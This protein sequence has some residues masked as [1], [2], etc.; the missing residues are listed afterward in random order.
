MFLKR[1]D[2]HG[3]KSFKDKTS[4]DFN[5]GITTIVGPNGSGKSNIADGFRWVLGEQRVKALR[6]KKGEDVIFNGT[7]THKPLGVSSVVMHIDNS[8]RHLNTPYEEMKIGRKIYRSGESEY[9]INGAVCRLK[10]IHDLFH[11]TGLGKDSFSIIGQG[12]I[13]NVL[14]AKP[15]DRRGMIEELAGIVK[16][17]N[18]KDESLKKIASA[19]LNL[20]RVLD[21]LNELKSNYDYLKNESAKAERFLE[22]K[23]KADQL[24]LSLIVAD[25]TERDSELSVLEEELSNLKDSVAGLLNQLEEKEVTYEQNKMTLLSLEDILGEKRE[26]MLSLKDLIAS[27]NTEIIKDETLL[28]S[29]E[30]KSET[31]STEINELANKKETLATIYEDKLVE[32]KKWQ[33]LIN[34]QKIEIKEMELKLKNEVDNKDRLYN[35]EQSI[36]H[37]LIDLFQTIAVLNNEI[38]SAEEDQEQL[39]KKSLYFVE[40]KQQLEDQ[41]GAF[42]KTIE[43]TKEALAKLEKELRQMNAAIEE[44]QHRKKALEHEKALLEEDYRKENRVY[45]EVNSK[46]SALKDIDREYQGYYSGVKNILVEKEN[47]HFKSIYGA[48]GQLIEVDKNYEKSIE[49]ALGGALQNVVVATSQ[50]AKKA[51]SFLKQNHKG[52]CTF[53]PL[54]VIKERQ[55]GNNFKPL[56][57]E[58]GV[59]GLGKDLLKVDSKFQLVVNHLLGNV[60]IVDTVD[61]GIAVAKKAN[62]QIKIVTLEGEQFNP[63]GSLTGGNNGKISSLLS[64][65]RM[66][67]ELEVTVAEKKKVL[68]AI[69]TKGDSINKELYPLEG[70]IAASF[71]RRK[72]LENEV[73]A[74]NQKL[75]LMK[76]EEAGKVDKI[77]SMDFDVANTRDEIEGLDKEKDLLNKRLLE[78]SER[79]ETLGELRESKKTEG[80]SLK[81]IIE[82]TQTVILNE[83]MAL[84]TLEEKENALGEFLAAYYLEQD[85]MVSLNERKTTQLNE[86]ETAEKEAK[87][88]LD[89]NQLLK[90]DKENEYESLIVFIQERDTGKDNLRI[91]NMSLEKEIKNLNGAVKKEETVL[92]EKEIKKAKLETDKQNKLAILQEKFELLPF[93]AMEKAIPLENKEEQRKE[94]EKLAGEISR[95][96]AVNIGAIDEFQ[97]VSD[98]LLFL[99]DQEG[100]LRESIDSLQTIVNDIDQIMI[101]RFKE[102]FTELNA[103]FKETYNAL[104]NGGEAF[105]E[106]TD[107]EDILNCGIEIFSKPP[108]KTPKSLSSL[109]GGERA[110][111]ALALL[112]S[113]LKIK[114]SPLCIIDEADASLD[115]RNVINFANYL[116]TYADKTQFIVIS[117]RQGTIEGSD[118]LYGVT[119]DKTGISKMI[120]VSMDKK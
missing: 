119:M 24:E 29:L 17:R 75:A 93:E 19:E 36:H 15:E 84:A 94:Q 12:E 112:F 46:Y 34:N 95:L 72:D 3:F 99:Q 107:K 48:V 4:L 108:G 87:V 109:S 22:L 28:T 38:K 76:Q 105:M 61:T 16:Y 81:S 53:L 7:T 47:G 63:G 33:S 43:T 20:T 116:K 100:D 96:G 114:P 70:S 1:F 27:L 52:R 14:N 37:D 117:H 88:R 118:T 83:K 41:L 80:E 78:E 54:D 2:L 25:I 90:K 79:K 62:H 44:K 59:I 57:Q 30:E 13:D 45:Q 86:I 113:F 56:L 35:E 67:N 106:L 9:S 111:T 55:L 32:Q 74:L 65:N 110:L 58:K 73:G 69:E 50:E 115:E 21:I 18:R 23:E 11:D 10:E 71:I 103:A 40:N 91:E 77:A 82:K 39:H 68:N 31:I 85:D 49:V 120:S 60:L 51:I 66:I 98:R 89:E 8:D 42:S 102:A 97:R 104:F 92:H 6:G 5:E 64:R 26:H 101:S